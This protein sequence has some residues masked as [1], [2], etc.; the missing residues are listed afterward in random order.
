M[1]IALGVVIGVVGTLVVLGLVVF[2]LAGF[3]GGKLSLGCKAFGR[4]LRDARFAD[5]VRPLIEAPAIA[6]KPSAAPLWLLAVLHREGRLLDFLLENIHDASPDQIVAAVK[7]IHPRCQAALKKYLVLEPVLT[8][9]EGETVE[10]PRGFDPSAISL[11]GNIT[12][13]P[14]FRGTLIH[15]G[16]RV[17]EIKLAPPPEG[18]DQFVVAPAVVELP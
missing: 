14:P 9:T 15:P 5:K 2:A 7:E 16:W 18:Q 6:P 3:D 8:Q 12:G 11:T 10:V 17:K 1:D 13:E 4:T